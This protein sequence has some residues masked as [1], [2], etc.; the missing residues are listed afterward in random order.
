MLATS[1]TM[2]VLTCCWTLGAASVARG[3]SSGAG[4]CTYP[5]AGWT[6]MG[7][8][9]MGNGGFVL[10]VQ[11]GAGAVSR[12][13]P[14]RGYVVQITNAVAYKG[15]L[16][17]SVQGEPGSPGVNGVGIFGWADSTLY[18]HGPCA[19]RPASV[20]HTF[21]RVLAPRTSDTFTWTAPT[22]GTGPVTFHLVRVIS[23]YFWYGHSDLITM[24][25]TE[26]VTAL[27]PLSWMGIKMLYR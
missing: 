16:L 8:G 12:Y 22:A 13:Q 4:A 17:Q 20:T 6:Q 23:Q 26:A 21:S 18:A 15:F 5:N 1:R 27:S 7:G 19:T 11:D 14:G 9:R 24:T 10:S 2:A 25:L 3:Y